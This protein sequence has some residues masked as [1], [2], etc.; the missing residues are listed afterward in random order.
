MEYNEIM[1]ES[2]ERNG[3]NLVELQTVRE[4]FSIV[5]CERSEIFPDRPYLVADCVEGY[6]Y[7][8]S[9]DLTYEEALEVWEQRIEKK[10]SF[11]LQNWEADTS[12]ILPKM[13][14]WKMM[15]QVCITY[16]DEIGF[17]LEKEGK[18]TM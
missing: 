6:F 16:R 8:G 10:L 4:G 17:Y 13:E 2:L 12:Q 18:N 1:Q 11:L 14:E 9:Y 15:N 3:W 7:S 5:I